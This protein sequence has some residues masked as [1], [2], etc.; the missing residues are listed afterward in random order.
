MVSQRRKQLWEKLRNKWDSEDFITAIDA[1][2]DS[3]EQISIL[4]KYLEDNPNATVSE[5]TAK[6]I[7][8]NEGI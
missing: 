5:I 7:F 4:M 3:E 1:E 2:M 6:A 8:I